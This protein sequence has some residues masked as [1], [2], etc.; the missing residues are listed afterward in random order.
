M[1]P[2][3]NK[4]L[5]TATFESIVAHNADKVALLSRRGTLSFAGLNARANRLARHLR[6]L[7]SGPESVVGV[8]L[9]KGNE[10]IVAML[11]CW[12][13]GAAYLPLDQ[14]LPAQRMQ[15]MVS[16]SGASCL[17]T[18]KK[19]LTEKALRPG[20][21]PTIC[22]DDRKVTGTLRSYSNDNIPLAGQDD[23]LAYI[24]YTSGT[25]GN[26]KGVAFTHASLSNLVDDIQ[27]SGEIQPDDRVLLFSPMC[28]DASI[29]DINGALMV[30][31]TLY[32]P[33][34]E[35]I[36]PGNL[37]RTI[38]QQSI[39]NPVITPSVLR[40]C[41][42][43]ELPNFSTLVL[44]GEAAD[45]YLI[46]TWGVGR[47][48]INAYGPTE[49]T[50]CSTKRVY[51][52]GQIPAGTS[53]AVTGNPILNTTIS[54]LDDNDMRVKYGD[55]GEIC[56]SGP[57]VS[58][59]GYL[60]LPALTSERFRGSSSQH[61]SYKTGDLGRITPQGEIE[62]LGRKA[63]TRQVKLS[64]GIRVEPEE[65][66]NVIRRHCHIRDVAVL[67]CGMPPTC[68]LCAFVVLTFPHA[69][70]PEF[71]TNLT[72]LM[73][74]HL[75]AYSIPSVV[76][77]LDALPLTVNR[78]LDVKALSY[79]MAS[80]CKS[81]NSVSGT[82]LTPLE[83]KISV[84][85]LDALNLPTDR[86]V[87]PETTYG[88]LGGSS[89]R[90]SLV[91][92]A[93]NATLGCNIRLADFFRKN[94][95]IRQLA[96]LV[97]S[98]RDEQAKQQPE[99]SAKWTVLPQDIA[100]N[101]NAPTSRPQRH[102]LLTGCT[103]FLG[104][105]L[106]AELLTTAA[107]RVSCI[108]RARDSECAKNRVEDALRSW[109]LWDNNF[110]G[111]FDVYCGNIGR[112]FLG[113]NADDYLYLARDVDTI[114]HSA[115]T[116]SFIAPFSELEESNVGGTVEILRF[117]STLVQK[118]LTYVSTLSFFFGAGDKLQC[119]KEIP[120]NDLDTGIVTGYAQSK[121]VSEQLVLE[122][123]Q[124]GGHALILR[125]GRLLG[126]TRN[127]KCPQDDFTIRLLYSILEMGVA[128][129][130]HDIGCANW[131]ID[132]TPVN[133]CARMIHQDSL[134]GKTGIQNIINKDTISFETI[135]SS[136]G[137]R[138]KPIPYH[139]WLRLVTQSSHLAPL[140]SVFHEPIADQDGRSI[141]E[142][143]LQMAIFRRSNYE[144]RVLSCEDDALQ[145][146]ST[147]KLLGQYLETNQQVCCAC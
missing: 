43:E 123:A 38:V 12:K 16:D 133:F 51:H 17:I 96:G 129:D 95:S 134:L 78:K 3:A 87:S 136:M 14:S 107:A 64:G 8:A 101:V 15:Y 110:D 131:Q 143:L 116:V 63:S 39:T 82:W 59:R 26:P 132:L 6:C 119:G 24:I 91:L 73:G 127:F 49:A 53:A 112:P 145:L 140:S 89:L 54:I 60:N 93:M 50:V 57:S 9:E 25:T 35:E 74:Q 4:L 56:V 106:L 69:D 142:A 19:I 13:I 83:K 130:L 75:P 72:E 113:L 90:A 105:H 117:A 71:T 94:N 98:H 128:P 100:D 77:Y 22:L 81:P 144:A 2:N 62:Y 114:Y 29:R 1:D 108:V 27:Q 84:A 21:G 141:F 58:R 28:F 138:I 88:E 118:R 23:Q 137:P 10:Y 139:Q 18:N 85:L 65:V 121:W 7:G 31:A 135:C 124:L 86:S 20:N 45:E 33:Q 104:S 46:R 115:A 76:R 11:A 61:R 109:H 68:A 146:P 92:R 97:T 48:L 122:W 111:R 103:G 125:P 41:A 70:E 30:G 55:V 80:D 147:E 34:E 47:R 102:V 66:E 5:P 40:S 126:S 36:L 42:H 44:A 99:D 52:D 120:V 67:V 37:M 79:T 32:V